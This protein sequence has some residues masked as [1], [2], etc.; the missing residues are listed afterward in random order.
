[1]CHR[2]EYA[3]II[4]HYGVR[5]ILLRLVCGVW[6]SMKVLGIKRGKLEVIRLKNM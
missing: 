5:V 2:V 6:K 4:I 1:M 3:G